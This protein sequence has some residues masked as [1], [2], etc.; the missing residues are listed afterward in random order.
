MKNKLKALIKKN[1]TVTAIFNPIFF[2]LSN[3]LDKEKLDHLL[4]KVPDINVFDELQ[5][6]LE[7]LVKCQ[8][9]KIKFNKNNLSQAAKKHIG[10][11][12]HE[13][14]G[15]WVYYP[16]SNRLVHILDELEFIEVRTSR[17][18]YKITPEEKAIL[19]TKKIGVMG[20]SVGQSVS[21]TMVMERIFGE[22]RLADFDIL[23]LSNYNR[24][25]TGLHNLGVPKVVAVAREIAEIDP[26]LKV[27][28]YQDGINEENIDDFFLKGGKLDIVLDECD[29]LHIKILCRQKAKALQI[30][31]IMETSD[32]G[33]VDVERFDLEPDRSILHGLIDHLDINKVKE[34]KTNE[35]KIPYLL[36]MV[37]IETIST[38][39]KASM[40]EVEQTITTWPQLASAVTLGG[41]LAT[42]V[43][44]RILL[45][46]FH[47]SGRYFVDIEELICDKDK[48]VIEE[49]KLEIRPS[50]SD[51]EMLDIIKNTNTSIT[52]GQ[53]E[54]DQDIVKQLV[55]AASKAPSGAN[56]QSWKWMWYNKTLYL[57]LDG[58]YTAG[59]LDCGNTTS[60]VG[61]GAAE[62]IWDAIFE[63][64]KA[65]GIKPIGLGARDTL[66][67]EMGFCLYGNDI[68]D[69][70]SPLEAGL[71]WITKFTK[72][73][74][75]RKLLEQQKANGVNKKLVG[76]EMVDKG[77]ARHGYEIKNAKGE[78]IGRVTSGT[79]SPSLGK[80]IG[81]GYVKTPFATPET[82]V[83]ISIRN[84]LA[85]AKLVKMPFSA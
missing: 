42:D 66:R 22:L 29:G 26:F 64:G 50:L 32:R 81:M 13:E 21:I 75:S 39:L 33:M 69:T 51:K 78:T 63:A 61:L 17:N 23:E 70:T 16:W 73:F 4:G 82:T 36:P 14:Y 34:A 20:L 68:D 54:L 3:V 67:L 43:C 53:L 10:N 65:A 62:K 46:Q 59:L 83:Y 58:I 76:F 74:T 77:I 15:V 7:E 52:K 18:Q 56:S 80:A 24:I 60:L 12:V 27:T 71:G 37:G 41:S 9:P 2:R 31:V 6:Q 48:S 49:K 57:F 5:G 40:V 44:R 35:E 11:I 55:T 28:C 47:D 30:P 19:A 25:R 1:E 45:N 79:Q 85:K 84:S 38:R 8:N 72:D